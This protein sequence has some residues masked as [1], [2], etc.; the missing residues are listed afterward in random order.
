MSGVSLADKQAVTRFLMA[1]GATIHEL[2]TVRTALSRIKGGGLARAIRAGTTVSL[3]ISDVIGDPLEVIASGPTIVN[4]P[5]SSPEEAVAVL[6]KF[7]AAPPA[8]P[9]LPAA[10]RIEDTGVI[11][12]SP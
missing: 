8:V 9:P 11:P 6:R 4:S 12:V 2:N 5:G 3:I 10:P 7:G 1:G